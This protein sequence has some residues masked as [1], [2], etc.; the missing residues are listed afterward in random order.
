MRDIAEIR[1]YF[2]ADRFCTLN[3]VIIESITEDYSICTLDIEERHLNALGNVQGGMIFTIAD[4]AFAVHATAMGIPTVLRD[5]NITYLKP[6]KGSKL[7]AKSFPISVGRNMCLYKTE[8][9]DDRNI[10]VAYSVLNGFIINKTK[11]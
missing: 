6:V 1:E 3:G 10:L 2:K 8:L 11:E 7:I 4:F 5:G 9:Y